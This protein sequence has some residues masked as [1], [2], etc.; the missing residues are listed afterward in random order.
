M[1]DRFPEQSESDLNMKKLGDRIIKQ[2][3]DSVIEKYRDLSVFRGSIIR[4]GLL[5]RQIMDL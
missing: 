3:L 5:L 2:L 1:A 4:L